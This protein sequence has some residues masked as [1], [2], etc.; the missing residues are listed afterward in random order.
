MCDDPSDEDV[1]QTR[2]RTILS[3]TRDVSDRLPEPVN[4]DSAI[5]ELERTIEMA[6]KVEQPENRDE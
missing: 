6:A 2:L 3:E 4:L 1:I 5:S